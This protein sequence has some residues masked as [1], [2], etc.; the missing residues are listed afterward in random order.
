M[1]ASK[2]IQKLHQ[3]L[4]IL[5]NRRYRSLHISPHLLS[6]SNELDTELLLINDPCNEAIDV[7]EYINVLFKDQGFQKG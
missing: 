2:T 6:K 1:I 4:F 5:W 7:A 3:L